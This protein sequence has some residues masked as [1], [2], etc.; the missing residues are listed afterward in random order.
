MEE[1]QNNLW[2]KEVRDI[3]QKSFEAR[4]FA[5]ELLRAV[6]KVNVTVERVLSDS[7]RNDGDTV[8]FLAL[9]REPSLGRRYHSRKR[10]MHLILDSERN[11]SVTLF[12]DCPE[13]PSILIDRGYTEIHIRVDAKF[14]K[15][16]H[17]FAECMQRRKDENKR[18]HYA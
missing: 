14:K 16:V 18:K 6:T 12:Y 10:W 3:L 4:Y 2:K 13:A 8:E 11:V 17:L 1:E 15:S 7:G 5:E 9:V